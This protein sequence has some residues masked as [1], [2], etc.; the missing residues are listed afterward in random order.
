MLLWPSTSPEGPRPHTPEVLRLPTGTP[1]GT[2]AAHS[3]YH[4]TPASLEAGQG[5]PGTSWGLTRVDCFQNSH[6][7]TAHLSFC[8]MPRKC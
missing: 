5:P 7:Y 2:G 1:E 4:L 8:K 6:Q 3:R